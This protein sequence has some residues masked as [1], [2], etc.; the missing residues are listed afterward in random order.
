MDEA[1]LLQPGPSN[2]FM[3]QSRRQLALTSS[4]HPSTIKLAIPEAEEYSWEWGNFPQKTPVWTAFNHGQAPSN[5]VK[6]K[7]RESL[8]DTPPSQDYLS[9]DSEPGSL[10]V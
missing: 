10:P 7:G 2:R 9:Y 6:G 3:T 1:H 8:T 5:D 4:E